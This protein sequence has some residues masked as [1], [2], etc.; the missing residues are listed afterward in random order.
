MKQLYIFLALLVCAFSSSAQ[1]DS[2]QLQIQEIENSLSYQYGEIALGDGL[3]KITVPEGFKYLDA[4]QSEYVLTELWGNPASGTTMGMLVPQDKGVLDDDVWVFDIEFDEIGYV[5]DKDAG[6]IDYTE[7]LASMQEDMLAVSRERMANGYEEIQLIG[8]ASDPYYDQES[9]ILHWAKELKFGESET[10]TLNYNVRILGR[11]GVLMLN[12]IANMESLPAVKQNIPLIISSV[13]FEQGHSYFDF[14][15]DIDE[16]ASWTIGG[17]VAGKVLTKV[18]FFA[19]ILKFW[20]VIAVAVVGLGGA[21]WKRLRGRKEE[22]VP[23]A[24]EEQEKVVS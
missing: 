22:D 12:A 2:L 5:E 13:A 18:G 1:T 10:N 23:V 16:V 20:K 6:D 15:P 21:L 4:E 14:N 7:L 19:L 17:L 24:E 8:W 3:A 9:K 11:R